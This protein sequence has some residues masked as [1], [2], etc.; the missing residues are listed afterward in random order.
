VIATELGLSRNTVRRFARAAGP[1]ELLTR[2]WTCYS[3]GILNDYEPYLRERWNS[4][5]ANATVLWQ[6]IRARGY[7]G[8][9]S[10]VRQPVPSARSPA[11]IWHA[12]AGPPAYLSSVNCW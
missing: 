7:P 5:C 12:S 11:V 3:P 4:G 6:E 10:T 1:G 8:G 2:D 9:Y